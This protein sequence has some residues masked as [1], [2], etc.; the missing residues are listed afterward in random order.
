MIIFSQ[1][2]K[3]IPSTKLHILFKAFS[4]AQKTYKLRIIWILL[5]LI[6]SIQP[7]Y[8]FEID[9]ELLYYPEPEHKEEI[10]FYIN[11]F[12]AR[13][14]RTF[15]RIQ[16]SITVDCMTPR[17]L[18]KVGYAD[19]WSQ[20][21]TEALRYPIYDD[22]RGDEEFAPISGVVLVQEDVDDYKNML[23]L[24]QLVRHYKL[25]VKLEVIENY[26]VPRYERPRSKIIKNFQIEL[27]Y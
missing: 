8:S 22:Y 7:S 14:G 10:N 9:E 11:K 3:L 18:W 23:Q 6:S 5:F 1:L 16:N 13:K 12:C 21:F 15:V 2:L 19:D 20:S 24:K 25:P 4:L 26:G 27:D 17:V